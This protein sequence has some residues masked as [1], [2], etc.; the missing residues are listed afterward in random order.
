M[1][2]RIWIGS[3]HGRHRWSDWRFSAS[4]PA[5]LPP[6]VH[7]L[8]CWLD[9][10]CRASRQRSRSPAR[11]LRFPP[12]RDVI[13]RRR[14]LAACA[15]VSGIAVAEWHAEHGAAPR[16]CGPPSAGLSSWS[17]QPV[18]NWV[19]SPANSPASLLPVGVT[20][21]TSRRI[22]TRSL[23]RKMARSPSRAGGRRTRLQLTG[24][25]KPSS[26]AG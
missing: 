22:A 7:K 17:R 18:G 6:P 3:A 5:S 9:G 14:L 2:S 11:W 26:A 1:I 8:R 25:A 19:A 16:I 13:S 24:R 23:R 4:R 21:T 10:P 20:A 12:S 15:E